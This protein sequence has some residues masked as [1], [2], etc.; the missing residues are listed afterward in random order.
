MFFFRVS[1]CSVL[2]WFVAFAAEHEALKT[3]MTRVKEEFNEYERKDIK[4]SESMKH[5]KEQV[6]L[7]SDHISNMGI[8]FFFIVARRRRSALTV[9][10]T[11][12]RCFSSSFLLFFMLSIFFFACSFIFLRS[13]HKYCSPLSFFLSS[14]LLRPSALL[15]L[16]SFSRVLHPCSRCCCEFLTFLYAMKRTIPSPP[17]RS[18]RNVRLLLSRHKQLR[19]TLDHSFPRLDIVFDQYQSSLSRLGLDP[20]KTVVTPELP[21]TVS[22]PYHTLVPRNLSGGRFFRS[23]FFIC[24]P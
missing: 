19:R 3:E 24:R 22:P 11:R 9:S 12:L 23:T 13:Y 2:V 16:F 15:F 21:P 4:H 5:L 18:R 8:C 7:S 6:S 14:V 17:A 10:A 20:T 1:T